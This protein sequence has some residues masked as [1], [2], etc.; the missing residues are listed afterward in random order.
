[1]SD[2]TTLLINEAYIAAAAMAGAITSLSLAKWQTMSRMEIFFALSVGFFFAIFVTPWLAH[3]I[4]NVSVSNIRVVAAMTYGCAAGSN[5]L[6]PLFI[7]K[8]AKLF[9][10]EGGNDA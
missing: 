9:G 8:I 4:L 6:L 7:R 2:K 1:M 5:I 3:G 10:D